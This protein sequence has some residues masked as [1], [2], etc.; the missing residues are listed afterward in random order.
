LGLALL[1]GTARADL[2][3]GVVPV[4]GPSTPAGGNWMECAVRIGNEGAEPER[5]TIELTSR[6]GYASDEQLTVRAPFA[7]APGSA[8]TVRMPIRTFQNVGGPLE[9]RVLGAGGQLKYEASVTTSGSTTPMVVDTAE[10]P[11]LAAALRD[12]LVAVG[13]DPTGGALP[14]PAGAG[15][16]PISTGLVR[17]DP[18]T[19]DP[20]LPDRA[21]GYASATVVVMRSDQLSR[22]TGMPLDALA[23]YVLSGGT[24]ALS[25]VR[26]EDLRHDV[27]MAL[28]G[29]QV[30]ST[31]APRTL[32][33]T[34]GEAV[35]PPNDPGPG[36][37]SPPSR[38]P[39]SMFVHPG[40]DVANQ[41]SG[42]EGGNLRPTMYGAAASYGLGEVHI[43]AFDPTQAP[44][45]DDP[46]VRSRMVELVRH[47]WDRRAY[48]VTQHAGPFPDDLRLREVHRVLDPNQSS[49]WAII[50]AA[51][52]LA[53]YA[54]IAGPVNFAHAARHGRPLR[55]LWVLPA[56]SLG[57]FV[58]LVGLGTAA[59][60]CAGKAR[61]LTLIDAAPG[62]S[63][64]CAVR[65]RAFFTSASRELTV[66]AAALSS[67][68]DTA[69]PPRAGAKRSL[70]VDR[71]GVQLVGLST[72]PWET[73]IVREDGFASLGAGLSVQ[74]TPESDLV[75]T[76]RMGRDLRALIV[77]P[78]APR[79]GGTREARFVPR[80]KDGERV[81]VSDGA[82][83]AFAPWRTA[84]T[85][86]T[87]ADLS[88]VRAELERESTG[89]TAA[90]A[91]IGATAGS[92]SDWWPDDVPIV[93]AQ[94]DGGE[95]AS[96]DSGLL[97]DLDR[98]LIRVVGYGG[99]P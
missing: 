74:L 84:T 38:R 75:L 49:R 63:K 59:K 41:L 71:D 30:S 1:G 70:L 37:G 82:P 99:T 36:F 56:L 48:A 46:W 5:G 89:L 24:L 39:L 93:L 69:T 40:D 29:G 97:I 45:V 80:L 62:I 65:Y 55:A 79:S 19:G 66:R 4:L 58:L 64:A 96:A 10:P 77:V 25:V 52:L 83:I 14:R 16:V 91:A 23:N 78:P 90:W 31:P 8:V 67:V 3:V 86:L 12:V 22:L 28:V 50:V 43:L 17:L 44:G 35:S 13:Y 54:I 26:P 72:M 87:E 21:A 2:N 34:P 92:Y 57:S 42:Y 60:G 61:H 95:G 94:V 76:N 51:L 47:A 33:S 81:K 9:L 88:L 68:L 98:V 6:A 53:A 20:I 32:R 18:S 73:V 85:G 7:V 27:L 15:G 11:R